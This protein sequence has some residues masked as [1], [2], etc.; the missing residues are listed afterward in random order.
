MLSRSIP[1][2]TGKPPCHQT[3]SGYSAVYPRMYGET[4]VPPPSVV[5]VTGLSPHVRGNRELLQRVAVLIG[6][7]PACT[8]KPPARRKYLAVCGVYPRMYGET[9]RRLWRRCACS[10]LSPHVRGNRPPLAVLSP[11]TRSIPACTGKP[12]MGPAAHR[13]GR[14]YPRMYGETQRSAL[15]ARLV[16]G[17]SPHVRGNRERVGAR[18]YLRG[19]IPACTGKPPMR[20]R[21]S[22]S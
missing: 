12:P 22:R 20:W 8:G 14:V 1:A 2:C 3:R 19:S 18:P 15:Y 13:W 6:S 16:E 9:R 11:P 7:I 21:V 17:L 5:S 4:A 10:G